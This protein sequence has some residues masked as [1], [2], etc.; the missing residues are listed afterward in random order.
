VA[1]LFLGA[2]GR[3]SVPQLRGLLIFGVPLIF[4]AVLVVAVAPTDTPALWTWGLVTVTEAKVAESSELAGQMV[5]LIG[6]FHLFALTTHPED[7]FGALVQLGL[8]KGLAYGVVG[9]LQFIGTIRTR[10]DVVREAQV[11][12][13][14]RTGGGPVR[15]LRSVGPLVQPVL[16]SALAEASDREVALVLRG[17]E[18]PGRPTALRENRRTGL[19]YGVMAGGLTLAFGAALWFLVNL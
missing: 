11:A 4:V 17:F 19:D 12:R 10:I 5:A 7:L 18:L 14:L 3:V 2:L 1:L 15:R 9:G 8:P 16:L 6:S 13:G